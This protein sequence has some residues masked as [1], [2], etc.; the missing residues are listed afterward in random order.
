MYISN[1][2]LVNYRNFKNAKFEFN[3]NI[4][5]IIGENGS[6]KTNLFRA[7]R[8]LLD[9][10]LLRF[11]Y[12]LDKSDFNRELGDSWKGHWII[13]SLEFSELSH[14]EA[15]QALFIHGLGDATEPVVEK[16]TYNL[17]FRPNASKRLA[18]SELEEGDTAGLAH[19]LSSLTIDDYE[20]IFT[21]KSTVDFNDEDVYKELV[22]D[23]EN[24]KFNFD[25][26]VSKFGIKIPHQL[27][28]SN[29]VSFTF[30]KALRDVVSDFHN[31]R[32]NPLLTLLKH[33]SDEISEDELTPIIETV[34]EL[35][36]QIENLEDV[37]K[38]GK[39]IGT[40]IKEAVGETYAPASL[41]I[42]S[43]M[44][45]DTEKLLQ[46]LRLF[47]S[48]PA[49]DYEGAI[50]ELSLGGANLI[51]LTLKLLEYKYRKDRDRVANFLL[52][53]EPEAHI[54][55]HIQKTLFDNLEYKD[56]QIIYSTHSTHISDVSKIS[57]MNI[58]AKKRNYVEVYQP[59][60]GLEEKKIVKLERYLDAIRSNLLFAK[61]VILVEG[62]AEAIVIPNLIKKV[63]GVS[64]DELG[65]SLI[66]IGSTGFENVAQIFHDDRV[67]R[68]CAIIT[69]LDSAIDITDKIEILDTDSEAQK[70]EKKKINNYRKK[71][72]GSEDKGANRKRLLDDFVRE[73]E[74]TEAFYA[75][76]TFEVDFIMAGN[77]DVTV[78]LS[79]EVYTDTTTKEDSKND[80]E[81]GNKSKYGKRILTI[82]SKEGKGWM[83]IS[84][85]NLLTYKTKIPDYILDALLF[86]KPL[87]SDKNFVI[88][89]LKYRIEENF[90][91]N[92]T[93]VFDS[94]N[95]M[96]ENHI[97]DEIELKTIIGEVFR[98]IP[99]DQI[100]NKLFQEFIF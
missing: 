21:G 95:N 64:L 14:E 47:V 55:T 77:S 36:E 54:H 28:L 97:R 80:L 6:G 33:K 2:S 81:S 27:S 9:D 20:T 24:V 29:E 39:D 68:K 18:F 46:S 43:E 52:I 1:V 44:S 74:W 94:V 66:N 11:S 26:D 92:D 89:L 65:I 19:L 34:V 40:T 88:N 3:K 31:N 96:I 76:H 23:F 59:S 60:R 13:I 8:L 84:L 48:E 7:I 91:E 15:I 25:I 4:N 93:L 53:E 22:G 38:I 45:D 30:I 90:R 87:K 69:D 86:V 17:F 98:V 58:L 57:N 82:A 50:H 79:N 42:K 51:F 12:K 70:K 62:D 5:T 99:D 100:I 73:N 35:N 41:S 32:T 63:L 78:E 61:G 10:N 16:A 83:A 56:T 67:R 72:K 85:S 75:E 71:M 37:K 49:E